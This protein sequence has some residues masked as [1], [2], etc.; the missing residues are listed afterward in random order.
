MIVQLAAKEGQA[1]LPAMHTCM[2]P[3]CFTEF[4]D[5]SG[6]MTCKPKCD[7]ASCDEATGICTATGASGETLSAWCVFC[8]GIFHRHTRSCG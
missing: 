1:S 7:L 5:S 8:C 4:V 2:C 3:A 6:A